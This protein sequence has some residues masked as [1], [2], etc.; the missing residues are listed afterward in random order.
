M[1][2]KSA[3]ARREGAHAQRAHGA[4]ARVGGA[5]GRRKCV[6]R[7]RVMKGLGAKSIIALLSTIKKN[8]I[9]RNMNQYTKKLF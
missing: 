5:G 2:G 6:L 1:A 4:G 9:R 8:V 7:V 3:C